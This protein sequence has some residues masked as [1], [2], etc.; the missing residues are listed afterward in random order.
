MVSL[1]HGFLSGNTADQLSHRTW[2]EAELRALILDVVS[3]A[4]APKPTKKP[5]NF[6]TTKEIKGLISFYI[7]DL[8][9]QFGFD[10]F[11]PAAF[12]HALKQ[13]TTLR[14]GDHVILSDGYSRWDTQVADAM[15]T[16]RHIARVKTG[17]YRL[18][19]E[20]EMVGQGALPLEG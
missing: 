9:K 10:F 4:S 11:V 19:T 6:H 5:S 16:S 1:A 3:S 18:L 14:E 8:R 20:Q 2:S 13:F 7:D 17:W 15:K 12:R